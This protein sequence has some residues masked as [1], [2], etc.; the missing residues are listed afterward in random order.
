M[1]TGR[2][3][4]KKKYEIK[5]YNYRLPFDIRFKPKFY[6]I[7]KDGYHNPGYRFYNEPEAKRFA[8]QNGYELA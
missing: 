5:K 4:K 8:K 2:A 1:N 6:I 7:S 3:R